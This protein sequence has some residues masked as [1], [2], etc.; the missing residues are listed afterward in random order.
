M[1]PLS[2]VTLRTCS[3]PLSSAALPSLGPLLAPAF[4]LVWLRNATFKSLVGGEPYSRV[5]SDK[6]TPWSQY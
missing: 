1:I 3:P 2:M 6:Q 5:I 4:P